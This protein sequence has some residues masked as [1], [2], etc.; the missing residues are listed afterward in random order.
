M[1]REVI[2]IYQVF[3][4]LFAVMG[5]KLRRNDAS[6]QF[7]LMFMYDASALTTARFVINLS[8]SG[9]GKALQLR[10]VARYRSFPIFTCSPR[11][12]RGRVLP[13]SVSI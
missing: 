8:L 12:L 9:E 7:L 1:L 3:I 10:V 5:A 13:L 4:S 6:F 11:S 2:R